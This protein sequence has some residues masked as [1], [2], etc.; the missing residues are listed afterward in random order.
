LFY[1]GLAP[2]RL[3]IFS[4]MSSI[5]LSF[6]SAQY[7]PLGKVDY[8]LLQRIYDKGD[9]YYS[10]DFF[11]KPLKFNSIHIDSLNQDKETSFIRNFLM[12]RW[13]FNSTF[14]FN[15]DFNIYFT[16]F[17]NPRNYVRARLDLNLYGRI[18]NFI[19]GVKD[20]I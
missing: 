16:N 14:V 18:Y 10:D 2:D 15:P 20:K 12:K 8:Y 5:F 4:L 19:F 9:L 11:F 1:L 13:A 17:K 6:S 7:I 3:I